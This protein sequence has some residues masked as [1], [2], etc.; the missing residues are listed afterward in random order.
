[1]TSYHTLEL[2]Y[3]SERVTVS[4]ALRESDG[5]TVI[6]KSQTPEYPSL[7]DITRIK[8]EFE[9]S[10]KFSPKGMVP[11]LG[12][13][14]RGNGYTLIEEDVD[15][16]SLLEAWKL[17]SKTILYFLKLAISITEILADLHKNG[18]IHK[19]IKP[20]N[21]LVQRHTDKVFLIDLGLAS[22][23]HSEEQ[24]P[25]Q[26]ESLEGTL[27]YISP[28]QTGRMNRSIDFRSDLYSL[29]ITFYEL[30]A[31]RL[32]FLGTDPI[33]LVHAHIALS[34]TPPIEI[35]SIIPLSI[36]NLILKLLS[37]NAEDRYHSCKGLLEDLRLALELHTRGLKIE[38]NPGERE[39]KSIFTI[40][41]KLYGREAEV[42]FLL[43]A[44]DRITE[45][46]FKK[47]DK[48]SEEPYGGVKLVLV[49][50]ISGVGKTALISEVHKPIL[51]K[52]GYFLSGKFDQFKRN[53]PYF[54]LIQA[55]TG[56]IRQILTEKEEKIQMW[57]KKIDSECNPNTALLVELI[58]ELIHITGTQPLVENNCSASEAEE[59]FQTTFLKFVG[60]FARQE[61]PLTIFVDDLQWADLPTLKFLE[62]LT[63]SK[64][65]HHLFL[66]GAYRDNEVNALHPFSLMTQ[67][68]QKEGVDI[69]KITLA[70]LMEFF[71]E[72][73]ICDTLHKEVGSTLPE[74]VSNKTGG[75]PFFVRQFLNTLHRDGCISYEGDRG[76]SYDIDKI[77][78]FHYTENVV[79]MVAGRIKSLSVETQMILKIAS[80][81]GA[82][83]SLSQ[84]APAMN[85]SYRD[86]AL[87]LQESLIEGVILPEDTS[88]RSSEILSEDDESKL[89]NSSYRF[90]HDRVQQAANS[91]LGEEEKIQT[92]VNIGKTMQKSI[93]L[94]E[95]SSQIFEL[96]N[97]LNYGI[98]LLSTREEREA[99]IQLN[100]EAGLKA[101]ESFAFES[102]IQYFQLGISHLNEDS[103]Q[104]IAFNLQFELLSSMYKIGKILD[105]KEKVDGLLEFSS[106]NYQR[107]R[108]YNLKIECLSSGGEYEKCVEICNEALKI[109]NINLKSNITNKDI[110]SYY[111]NLSLKLK[112]KSNEDLINLSELQ[113]RDIK[114]AM[115]ILMNT[116]LSAYYK[117][118]IFSTFMGMIM[119]NFTIDY[120]FSIFSP[121]AFTIYGGFLTSLGEYK[122]GYNFGQLGLN[123]NY[124]LQQNSTILKISNAV[125]VILNNWVEHSKKSVELMLK[126]LTNNFIDK[127]IISSSSMI[128]NSK[129]ISFI[130]GT[131]LSKIIEIYKPLIKFLQINNSVDYFY[132]CKY[133]ETT[134]NLLSE[135]SYKWQDIY[136][137]E[138]TEKEYINKLGA[139]ELKVGLFC[140]YVNDIYL[141]YLFRN[142]LEAYNSY[143]ILKSIRLY[144]IGTLSS[145]HDLFVSSLLL[146]KLKLK[147]PNKT[148][149]ETIKELESNIKKYKTW[150]ENNPYN[151]LHK[152]NLILA[153]YAR[154]KKEYWNASEYYDI[155]IESAIQNEYNLDVGLCAEL[156]A[157]FYLEQNR[158][159]QAKK[160]FLISMY[161]YDLCGAKA[162]VNQI[163]NL[164]PEYTSESNPS[165]VSISQTSG[166]TSTLSSQ[167]GSIDITSVLR[168]TTALAEER[169]VDSLLRKLMRI[170]VENAGA[171]KTV[172]IDVE[173]NLLT[174]RAIFSI[175]NKEVELFQNL[176]YEEYENL[177]HSIFS[178]IKR[179][180]EPILI[181][182]IQLNKQWKDIK[183]YQNK[184]QFSVLSFP[185]LNKGAIK[186]ILYLE[187]S[188]SS[189]V[190]SKER[191]NVLQMISSQA[192][193]SIENARLYQSMEEKIQDRTKELEEKNKSIEELNIFIKTINES[194][195]LDFIL[196]KI[197]SH[198]KKNFSIEHF[199][200]GIAE[201]NSIYAR[202]VYLTYP[203]DLKS[204]EFIKATPIPVK[205]TKGAHS[206]AF[207]SNKPFYVK[208]IRLDR[209]PIE[210]RQVVEAFNLK[211]ILIIPLILKGENIGY[212]DLFNGNKELLI[213]KEQINQLSILAEQLAGII[214]S[215][216]L[217]K[218]L[219]SQKLQLETTLTE[220]RSTQE[221]LVEAEKSA[222]LGQLISGVAHEINNPLAA[223]RSSA[224]ILEMDQEKILEELP[225]FFQE[226]PRATLDFFLYL[227]AESEKNHKHLTSR[228]ERKRKKEVISKMESISFDNSALKDQTIELL[229]ELWLEDLYPSFHDK[230]SEE[231]LLQILKYSSLFSIQKN[232]LKNIKLSTEKSS[233]VIFSLRKYL[234][235]EIRGT[236]RNITVLEMIDRSLSV[237]NNYLQG[238]VTVIKE[239]N[240]NPTIICVVDDMLQVFKNVIFN[241]IQSMYLSE[242]KILKIKI[243]S[244]NFKDISYIKICFEDSGHGI[245]NNLVD[246]LFTPFFTTR[247]RGEGIGLGL[248]VSRTITEEHGGRLEYE[249]M[250]MGSKFILL[251]PF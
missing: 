202:T 93:N 47:Y 33:E 165:S 162:L 50:G 27:S 56:L 139:S 225:T 138:I 97:H 183:Y 177:P 67:N 205:S 55:F 3:K 117:Q 218:E 9:L 21:I 7:R 148:E 43:S 235:T 94:K 224:E 250:D 221:Q 39:A 236:P 80:C 245:E 64:D 210:E 175:E 239:V 127:D 114:V 10:Q 204:R 185:I 132:A 215:S 74:L 11:I 146:L 57:K 81:I 105:V 217:Y 171:T 219:Q 25:I 249:P 20:A 90:I 233:R 121:F 240:F 226:N 66:I 113:N 170:L 168:A 142:L 200:L 145:A 5:K 28:E 143:I 40:P 32:P 119:V 181:E 227:I 237:Y 192:S 163:K 8:Y 179:T 41:Q 203:E 234:K 91:L 191:L 152:Y 159:T 61:H 244:Y 2:I 220:L 85:L 197:H 131:D 222:A 126:T 24:A 242:S 232:A 247:A 12:M 15:G 92:H 31:S 106:T 103:S 157:E 184:K 23:L 174:V 1:M 216:N 107:A 176:S 37:K 63:K 130:I 87:S 187:N 230:F 128:A 116:L 169:N 86:T 101:G 26:P 72:R 48:E 228:E 69:L 198:I 16:V 76:W 84:L 243:E 111:K 17:S 62:L 134:I 4:R 178:Y 34:P 14:K 71:I 44:F 180:G 160:Y 189:H 150:S 135:K 123:L 35:N 151:F 78:S 201:K 122:S 156:A 79:E 223:I 172:L 13:E 115:E 161:Y 52:R 22:L 68:L 51:E 36:S 65:L 147:E 58:P 100:Y 229:T 60:V 110:F 208:R 231:I 166:I 153:E 190:F 241:A 70:P 109:F 102:A 154:Y 42:S 19:D 164:Y 173:E 82:S 141:K 108:V 206:L 248:Y 96:V 155:A 182:D 144:G 167:R 77:Q 45:S 95:D 46:P 38:F 120:G 207:D 129:V 73:M 158:I 29:G 30:L 124:K 75:N 211:S 188:N 212:F 98:H 137:N 195:D 246:K 149:E 18:I 89:Q 238:I 99:L 112:D 88:Y 214:H 83:F 125:G 199:G 251:F 209:I 196:D 104:E 136:N 193:I 140:F 54:S 194:S 53:I 133:L 186:G 118:P 213:S 6:L 59:R 49:G